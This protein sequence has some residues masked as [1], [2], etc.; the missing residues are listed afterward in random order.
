[1]RGVTVSSRLLAGC[2]GLLLAAAAGPSIFS[3]AHGGL[4]EI[5]REGRP[6]VRLCI[7]DPAILAEYENRAGRCIRTVIR[8]DGS[9][10]TIHYSCAGGSF[11]QSEVTVLTPRSLRVRT[12]GISGNAPFKYSFDARRMGNCPGH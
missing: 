2:C 11:G 4:W 12:Q 8:D 1:M 7:A 6:P 9:S 3:K 10:A 5:S